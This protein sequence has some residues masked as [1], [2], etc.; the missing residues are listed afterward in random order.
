MAKH[1]VSLVWEEPVMAAEAYFLLQ[2]FHTDTWVSSDA[3]RLA[4]LVA[5]AQSMQ[6]H[7]DD[8]PVCHVPDC[9]IHN[10]LGD[11]PESGI[12]GDRAG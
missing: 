3:A 11:A 6:M 10:H 12:P 7:S 9:K 2:K 1:Q 8:W 5:D 4:Y